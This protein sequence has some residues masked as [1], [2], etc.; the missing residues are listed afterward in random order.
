LLFDIRRQ[1]WSDRLLGITGIDRRKLPSTVPSGTIAGQV[2]RRVAAELGLPLGVTVVVG[3]HDQCCN[4]LGAGIYQSGNSVCGIGTFECITPAF[5]RI[6]DAASML[7][8]G[9]NVEHHVLPDLF[10]SFIYN[11][12]GVLVRWFRD[13]FASADSKLLRVG[14]N[15]YE[16]L[17]AELPT[18]PTRLLTL[19]YFEI[20]GPP[21]FVSEASGVILGLKTSTTRGE[22]LK[23]IMECVTF[24][25]VDS[26]R[27]LNAMGLGTTEF[28]ATGG[29]AKSDEWLQIKAD[30][31]N[32]P[33]VR[34]HSVE[35]SLLGA[36]I[37][38]GVSTGVW[39]SPAEGVA[40]CVKRERVFEPDAGRHQIYQ[41]KQETYRT[42]F[43]L[44]KDFLAQQERGLK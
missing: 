10:V 39:G 42:L 38:A 34:L 6:P 4:S 31:F 5:D 15:I 21:G 11:Q 3:G 17:A 16:V 2:S 14:E 18:E 41:A 32:V 25:F 40:Q 23:S 44:L 37:L 36:A 1:D 12:G 7:S 22:I 20:T 28:I 43:P 26:I 24:Y 27:A 19:P 9:L 8:H 13:T 29:G 35:G 30:I 33:F